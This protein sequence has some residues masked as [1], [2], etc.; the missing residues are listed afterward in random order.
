VYVYR[1][2]VYVCHPDRESVPI[3]GMGTARGREGEREEEGGEEGVRGRRGGRTSE[4]FKDEDS[5]RPPI[6][7]L[8]VSLCLYHKHMTTKLSD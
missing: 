2:H 5:E 6:H 4:H 3:E 7:R 1:R 8:S